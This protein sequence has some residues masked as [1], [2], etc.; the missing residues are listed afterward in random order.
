M[1]W[2]RKLPGSRREPHG[3]EWTILKKTPWALFYSA[4]IMAIFVTVGH[5][6]PPEGT[7]V[8]VH[9]HLETIKIFAIAIW[10][11]AWVAILTVAFG[12]FVV[13][14]MKGPA[15]VADELELTDSDE[16]KE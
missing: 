9:K 15:Y 4:L 14:L 2:L 16:P 10:V 11:A 7:A 13:Y 8:D 6:M 1:K 3:L 12:A 5:F